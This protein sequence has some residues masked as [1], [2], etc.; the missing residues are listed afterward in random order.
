MMGRLGT[1]KAFVGSV[2]PRQS[3][4]PGVIQRERA[5]KKAGANS[6]VLPSS[7]RSDEPAVPEIWLQTSHFVILDDDFERTE[8]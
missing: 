8:L 2:R 1:G 5:W 4:H 7:T 3:R 6:T